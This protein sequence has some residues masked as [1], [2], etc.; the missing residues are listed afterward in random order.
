MLF[1]SANV[2]LFSGLIYRMLGISED[3]FTPLFAISRKMCIRDR[4]DSGLRSVDYIAGVYGK[5]VYDVE[6]VLN[7]RC[8]AGKAVVESPVYRNL[9]AVS[10][11]HLDVYK[12]QVL[13]LFLIYR[14][15]AAMF[16][17]FRCWRLYSCMRLTC[18]SNS[19]CGS[20]SCPV[21]FFRCWAKITLSLIHI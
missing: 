3:L 11:T 6:D 19:V 20:I 8:E 1:R 17:A 7:G 12:R 13:G 18:T 15:C 14:Y 2:D 10:Y 5:T 4:L 16:S 21:T 9:Y